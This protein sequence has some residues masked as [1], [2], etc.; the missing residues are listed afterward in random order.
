MGALEEVV[1][2]RLFALLAHQKALARG[3]VDNHH[4][5]KTQHNG[6]VGKVI[7]R[8][9]DRFKVELYVSLG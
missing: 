3:D 5:S 1:L 2:A 8:Q 7:G 4:L 9:K 6:K